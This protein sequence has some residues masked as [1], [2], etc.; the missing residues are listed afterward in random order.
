VEFTKSLK[1]SSEIPLIEM[2]VRITT[3]L[4]T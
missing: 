2:E 1:L 3:S 4:G